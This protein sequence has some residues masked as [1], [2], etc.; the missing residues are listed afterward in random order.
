LCTS[1]SGFFE[2]FPGLKPNIVTLNGQFWFPIRRELGIGLGFFII[3]IIFLNLIGGVQASSH[4][5]KYLLRNPKSGALAGIVIGGAEE[6]LDSR[7]GSTNLNIL[8][9]HGFCRIALETGYIFIK[10]NFFLGDFIFI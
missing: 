4:S 10:K 5:L 3:F 2:K 7:P 9:R 6:L 1:A 8:G